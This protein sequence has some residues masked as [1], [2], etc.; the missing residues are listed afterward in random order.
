MLE[1]GSVALT[2][3]RR[4]TGGAYCIGDQ[5]IKL[6]CWGQSATS[7]IMA[8]SLALLQIADGGK[9]VFSILAEDTAHEPFPW[10]GPL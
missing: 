4:K 1:F 5:Q 6:F 2:K 10:R 3:R 8:L 7:G 9:L